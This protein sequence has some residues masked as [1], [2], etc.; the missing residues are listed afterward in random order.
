MRRA[1]T[2]LVIL[3][4][5]IVTLSCA[6]RGSNES[7][8]NSSNAAATQQPTPSGNANRA[9]PP[10]STTPARISAFVNKKEITLEY[11]EAFR[12]TDLS[13]GRIEMKLTSKGNLIVANKG[14]YAGDYS[15]LA[16]N[17]DGGWA[18]AFFPGELSG[19]YLAKMT[20][21]QHQAPEPIEQLKVTLA[22]V[23]NRAVLRIY[24]D[25]QML[26]GSFGVE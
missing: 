20:L 4:G 8:R 13:K 24:F 5:I 17:I 7:S 22:N 3:V 25:N 19:P 14:L 1:L 18:L 26:I 11:G 15:V 2:G 9:R 21:E 23:D 10:A 12:R 16:R 6:S